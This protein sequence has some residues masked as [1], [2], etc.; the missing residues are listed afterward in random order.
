MRARGAMPLTLPTGSPSIS[1]GTPL[2]PPAVVVVCVPWPSLSRADRNSPSANSSAG[3]PP[4]RNP[5]EKD[6]AFSSLLLQVNAASSGLKAVLPK[7]QPVPVQVAG[8]APYG[9]FGPL[10]PFLGVGS[11]LRL[12]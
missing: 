7:S 2:L 1:A 3:S 6:C 8:G 11:S 12:G 10:S 4:P 5:V 9:I